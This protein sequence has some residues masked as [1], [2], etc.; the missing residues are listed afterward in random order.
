MHSLDPRLSGYP[1][2]NSIRCSSTGCSEI[3]RRILESARVLRYTGRSMKHEYREEEILY[4][5]YQNYLLDRRNEILLFPNFFESRSLRRPLADVFCSRSDNK[6]PEMSEAYGVASMLMRYVICRVNTDCKNIVTMVSRLPMISPSRAAWS[7][8][9]FLDCPAIRP[10]YVSRIV[11]TFET[12]PK[13]LFY[14]EVIKERIKRNEGRFGGSTAKRWHRPINRF[15]PWYYHDVQP[16]LP[17]SL[18]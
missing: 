1:N 2:T 16:L 4:P 17:R 14:F 10:S 3:A 11:A 12:W 8:L 13:S 15:T 18:I 5:N 7:H 6:V 9:D